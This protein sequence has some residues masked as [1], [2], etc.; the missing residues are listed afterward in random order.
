MVSDATK[1]THKSQVEHT[2][3]IRRAR[4]LPPVRLNNSAAMADNRNVNPLQHNLLDDSS[5]DSSES[6]IIAPLRAPTN[7]NEDT[8]LAPVLEEGDM[9]APPPPP[10]GLVRAR[11][12]FSLSANENEVV[13]EIRSSSALSIHEE[14]MDALD[15][16]SYTAF[17]EMRA[18]RLASQILVIIGDSEELPNANLNTVSILT[19]IR[20]VDRTDIELSREGFQ[21]LVNTLFIQRDNNPTLNTIN[22]LI[23]ADYPPTE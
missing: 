5:S 22:D 18:S 3:R 4:G 6:S 2:N 7:Q 17:E 21:R 23:N 8:M 14:A 13:N 10:L 19:E 15:N 16:P 11:G 9:V 1:R 12:A 20:Q